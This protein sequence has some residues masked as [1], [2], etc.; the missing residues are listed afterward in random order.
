[1][2]Q[3]IG[4]VLFFMGS[5]VG[6]QSIERLRLD[7]AIANSPPDK[8]L[9]L[10]IVKESAQLY[11]KDQTARENW[12]KQNPDKAYR[13]GACY[14]LYGGNLT[15]GDSLERRAYPTLFELLYNLE[16]DV[17][18]H[19]AKIIHLQET[20]LQLNRGNTKLSEEK[21]KYKNELTELNERLRGHTA[22]LDASPE[23][24]FP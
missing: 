4:S 17:N 5:V 24:V 13:H 20:N 8:Y 1:M 7:T 14:A 18:R 22:H 6:C 16:D 12:L 11:Q 21:E 19:R 3:I 15:K 10:G 23:I 9:C 2:I